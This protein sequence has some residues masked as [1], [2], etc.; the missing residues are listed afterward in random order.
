[1]SDV[2]K[3]TPFSMMTAAD[4]SARNHEKRNAILYWLAR[5]SFSTLSVIASLLKIDERNARS[6]LKKMEAE[7]LLRSELLPS[8]H[9]LYGLT[10]S[11]IAQTHLSNT[12][13]A[14]IARPYQVGRVPLST[15]SHNINIQVAEISLSLFGW[16]DFAAGRELYALG[17]QQVPDL[18]AQDPNGHE[19]A[20]EVEL[21][22]KSAKRMQTIC[23]N[24]SEMVDAV[25]DPCIFYQR[26]LY[27]SPFPERLREMLT[28]Y[29]HPEKR[30]LFDVSI[31]CPVPLRLTP[32]RSHQA[33]ELNG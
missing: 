25:P 1:M 6:M 16:S 3:F 15:L 7:K 23:Q 12:Y 18:V 24:Y 30:W 13:L 8:G 4:I 20:I 17:S 27:L 19:T 28:K 14:K 33:G 32:R 5:Y 26:V 9:R 10:P 22:L 11:G 21:N 2:K 29:V 31:L